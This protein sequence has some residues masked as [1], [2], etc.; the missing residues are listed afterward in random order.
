MPPVKE[1]KK[2]LVAGGGVGGMQAAITAAKRGHRVVLCEKGPRLGG[3]L[4]CEEQVPFKKHLKEYLERQA[5]LCERNGVE[6]RLNTAVTPEY[7][8]SEKPDVIIA[9]T[10]ARPV[11]PPVEGIDGPNVYAA[12][13]VYVDPEKAGQRVV[14]LGAGLVGIEIGLFLRGLGREVTLVEIMDHPNLDF[15]SMHTLA[16]NKELREK[17]VPIRLSTR[18]TRIRPEGVEIQGPEG[19]GFLPADTVIYAAGMRPEREA[20]LA[21]SQ[22]APEFT[23]LGDCQTPKNIMAATQPAETAAMLIG[24]R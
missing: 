1:N 19:A 8:L 18:A 6:V 16:V 23:M 7:A 21:L 14:V 20:A 13:E 5:M 15:G 3:V 12:E 22:C 24:V 10:G 11:K 2:V 4:L 17:N 9:A